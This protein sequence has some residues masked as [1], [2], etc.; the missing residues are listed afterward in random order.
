MKEFKEFVSDFQTEKSIESIITFFVDND[1][2]GEKLVTEQGKIL[3]TDGIWLFW[4]SDNRFHGNL[5]ESL[6]CQMDDII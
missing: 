1:W 4:L 2:F 3:L 5:L 6:V